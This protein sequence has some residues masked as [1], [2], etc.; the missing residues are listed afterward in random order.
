M[1]R[2]LSINNYYYLRGGAETV[3]FE[4][5]R[6]FEASGWDVAPFSMHHP[7][8]FDT[9]W[10]RYFVSKIELGDDYT[11]LEKIKIA[12]KIIYSFEA[13]RN[14]D[15]LIADFAPD[16]C[17]A[18]NV[19]H[20]I[21]PAI[22]GLL[23]RRG[24]PVVLTLHDLKIACPSYTMLARDGIC[25]RCKGGGIHNVLV[26]RCIKGSATLSGV[27]LLETMLH[28]LLG[29]YSDAVTRFVVPSRFYASK[30]AEWGFPSERFV[31]VPNFVDV[32]RFTP[33]FAPG[34][35]F[36]YMGRL[37]REKGVATL[38][39]AVARA[40]CSLVVIG[41]GPQKHELEKL[42]TDLAADVEFL[43]YQT[44][45]ALHDAVRRGRAVVLP[46]E[47]YENAPM[48]ILEAYALGKPVVGAKIGGIPELIREGVTGHTF[49]SGDVD[50]LAAALREV[51]DLPADELEAYGREARRWVEAELSIDRYK[52]RILDVYRSLGVATDTIHSPD[53]R[54]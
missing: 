10:S 41:T 54:A 1:S 9:P 50:S 26:H 11:T 13:R 29:S 47:W 46:S 33:S 37:S 21:S 36:V 7:K 45:P 14:L 6:V 27:V 30:F 42:A 43:G 18:H 52:E 34:K 40:G 39:R 24:I 25:E 3:F 17:H 5:N 35:R 8:N 16:I 38:I 2:L 44:G 15:R 32:A 12:T 51:A 28:R 22:F 4:H 19:Y 20:H 23:K 31:H 48:S 53:A 49:A